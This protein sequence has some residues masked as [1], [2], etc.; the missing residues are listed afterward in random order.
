M[1][2]SRLARRRAE[3]LGGGLSVAGQRDD[4][5]RRPG[6]RSASSRAGIAP[7]ADHAPG[8]EPL[9]DLDGHRVRRCPVAPSTRT[10]WPRPE[11]GRGGAG[12]PRMT[13][14]G[15]IAAAT[16]GRRRRRRA[17]R[18]L[19]RMSARAL[20]G[21]RAGGHGH[22]RRS[23]SR[24]AVR[25]AG[26]RRRCRG[27][28]AARRCWC[29]GLRPRRSGRARAQA[30]GEDVHEDRVAA[31]GLR[32][33]A[34]LVVR[35]FVER[36]HDGG[37]V[38]RCHVVPPRRAGAFSL[39]HVPVWSAARTELQADCRHCRM[40]T[41]ALAGSV[42]DREQEMDGA[43]APADGLAHAGLPDRRHTWSGGHANRIFRSSSCAC[44]VCCAT[45]S[46]R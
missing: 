23:R 45:A 10:L 40:A 30:G 15:S 11:A 35:R 33:L 13:S 19:R 41:W 1:T 14:P 6:D 34:P 9:G 17:A 36:R 22:R 26:R 12:P 38:H 7:G 21:H 2:T 4:L 37:G 29:S 27:S 20:L 3:R 24:R 31:R 5:R 39:R 28:W 18:W 42:G 8:A 43:R 46:R 44:S 32:N 25:R 16:A